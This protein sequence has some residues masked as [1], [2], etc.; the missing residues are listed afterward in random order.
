M[1]AACIIPDRSSASPT[2]GLSSP[3][4]PCD[5]LRFGLRILEANAESLD[6]DSIKTT[7]AHLASLRPL[8]GSKGRLVERVWRAV[9]DRL[10]GA[11]REHQLFGLMG[12]EECRIS[13]AAALP[14]TQVCDEK[15]RTRLAEVLAQP[16]LGAITVG[17][18]AAVCP[19]YI[20][21]GS[22]AYIACGQAT[23]DVD[24][25]VTADAVPIL[26]RLGLLETVM[27]LQSTEKGSV[28]LCSFPIV[29]L[30]IKQGEIRTV[31]ARG[32]A[33]RV[34]ASSAEISLDPEYGSSESDF[35]AALRDIDMG[36]I[37]VQSTKDLKRWFF[38]YVKKLSRGYEPYSSTQRANAIAQMKKDFPTQVD[39]HSQIQKYLTRHFL[40]RGDFAGGFL[41]LLNAYS[42]LKNDSYR[43]CLHGLFH[44]VVRHLPEKYAVF[45]AQ[46][47]GPPERW[48]PYWQVMLATRLLFDGDHPS[49]HC[50]D[51]SSLITL[52]MSA[53]PAAA[54]LPCRGADLLK[55]I[56]DHLAE[57][58]V[59]VLSLLT[60]MC[61]K[62]PALAGEARLH[63]RFFDEAMALHCP[64]RAA[65]FAEQM[66]STLSVETRRDLQAR[67]R[68]SSIES[69]EIDDV[70]YEEIV[71]EAETPEKI[72]QSFCDRLARGSIK[73][74]RKAALCQAACE[75]A[76][77]HPELAPMLA[78][79]IL[80]HAPL[81]L[82]PPLRAAMWRLN[83]QV[84]TRSL[85]SAG[86]PLEEAFKELESSGLSERDRQIAEFTLMCQSPEGHEEKIAALLRKL[87]LD[88][89]LVV[90][91]LQIV[92]DLNLIMHFHKRI[93]IQGRLFDLLRQM[94]LSGVDVARV[95]VM[96]AQEVRWAI[97]EEDMLWYLARASSVSF[98]TSPGHFALAQKAVLEGEGTEEDR[99]A[100]VHRLMDCF[101]T[102]VSGSEVLHPH[103]LVDRFP[104]I[105]DGDIEYFDLVVDRLYEVKRYEEAYRLTTL[106]LSRGH[107]ESF[108]RF[109]RLIYAE[110][111]PLF[112]EKERL[113]DVRER[114]EALLQSKESLSLAAE[115]VCVLLLPHI[116]HPAFTRAVFARISACTL[117]AMTFAQVPHSHQ[118]EGFKALQL[119][120]SE[121]IE[122]LS[123]F[124][125]RVVFAAPEA[126]VIDALRPFASTMVDLFIQQGKQEWL[127]VMVQVMKRA[128]GKVDFMEAI[129][130]MRIFSEE[131]A[132]NPGLSAALDGYLLSSPP[133]PVSMAVVRLVERFYKSLN[134]RS[135]VQ[136]DFLMQCMEQ[137]G[138]SGEALT[139]LVAHINDQ[140]H[141]FQKLRMAMRLLVVMG[142]PINLVFYAERKITQAVVDQLWD[143]FTSQS[144]LAGLQKTL[145]QILRLYCA[146][147]EKGDPCELLAAFFKD[148]VA[149]GDKRDISLKV[150]A[151]VIDRLSIEEKV[152]REF[153]SLI[154]L[155]LDCSADIFTFKLE[156]S[157]MKALCV[158][159]YNLLPYCDDA[160]KK[161]AA[162]FW[163][164]ATLLFQ[165]KVDSETWQRHLE[166]TQDRFPKVASII[167]RK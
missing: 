138:A 164:K 72:A 118:L 89:E 35:R 108:W 109:L 68:A 5:D 42:L 25:M 69:E 113:I 43:L 106:Q 165:G 86:L 133:G 59:D 37:I 60:E 126:A 10:K 24:I 101:I 140:P 27:P 110:Q 73:R 122:P 125:S 75:F 153:A 28:E 31:M 39:F 135:S 105:L 67:M 151:V 143:F 81:Q 147:Y 1:A 80:P 166:F 92:R 139:W 97:S 104:E 90:R 55:K 144:E 52:S 156:L 100:S 132:K 51:Y 53:H 103:H 87:P 141:C 46:L 158:M 102:R 71:V 116:M 14:Y 8:E 62:F 41:F 74:G 157:V 93:E 64:D 40:L 36:R 131:W 162:V 159:V 83:A 23:A 145:F 95:F 78:K 4:P 127:L 114:V 130:F 77:D 146:V 6:L 137:G 22:A 79:A 115:T 61:T 33:L 85:L 7:V 20:V 16:I 38:P 120:A 34:N 121:D 63:Q 56:V 124:L 11:R 150:F 84:A 163:L 2:S 57:E 99:I 96:L 154:P 117:K 149:R 54:L 65:S 94:R 44:H 49:L 167:A 129:L 88:D 30:K 152:G 70:I 128:L 12:V 148:N 107:A 58:G 19:V 66:W 18:L 155:I 45:A 13:V 47:Y 50:I 91:A 82:N 48:E 98:L 160:T 29:D 123:Q 161:R 17:S 9:K 76:K 32:D 134:S 111:A 15:Q 119:R 136:M 112:L 142:N 21:G 3:H 26:E